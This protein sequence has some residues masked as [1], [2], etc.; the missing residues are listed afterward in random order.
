MATPARSIPGI[1]DHPGER[2]ER[3]VMVHLECVYALAYRMTSD[4]AAA[5]D[6]VQRTFEQAFRD[7]DEAPGG[8]VR[9][10]LYRQF[11]DAWFDG[12]PDVRGPRALSAGALGTADDVVLHAMDT[13]ASN[14]RITVYLADVEG[15]NDVE[16]AH[17]TGVPPGIVSAR[18]RRAH[19]ELAHRLTAT[20]ARVKRPDGSAPPLPADSPVSSS[21]SAS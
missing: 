12:A 11:A 1:T 7:F 21:R 17:I 13:L 6:L 15:F 5:E 8:A 3:E 14:A 16:I 20:A 2:F 10:W 4:Q 9:A 18:L 19:C